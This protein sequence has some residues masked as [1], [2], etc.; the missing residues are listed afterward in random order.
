MS[1]CR[2][3]QRRLSSAEARR[4]TALDW[5]ELVDLSRF[6]RRILAQRSP[7][8]GCRP[9]PQVGCAAA[10]EAQL[11][12]LTSWSASPTGPA[13]SAVTAKRPA[14]SAAAEAVRQRTGE[15]RFNIHDADDEAAVAAVREA[16]GD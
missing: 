9:V 11:V 3:T 6:A 2:A 4:A 5:T 10:V 13:R 15:V 1:T 12:S 16:V 7:L 14:C 8:L